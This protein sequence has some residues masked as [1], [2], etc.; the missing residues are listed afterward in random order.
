[1]GQAYSGEMLELKSMKSED[2]WITDSGASRHMA[3]RRE[4]LIDFKPVVSEVVSLGNGGQC[5]VMG[6]GAVLIEKLVSNKWQKAR[7]EDVLP[8]PDIK[9][10]L[11]SV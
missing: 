6:N 9:R 2:T 11:F 3:Y 8:V 1:M 10:N 7:I 4:W 5:K